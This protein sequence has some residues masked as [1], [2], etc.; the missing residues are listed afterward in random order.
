MV[1]TCSPSPYSAP[2]LALAQHY[3]VFGTDRTA[4]CCSTRR[5][6]AYAPRFVIGTLSRSR[7]AALGGLASFGVSAWLVDEV[8]NNLYTLLSSIP[9]WL[10]IAACVLMMQVLHRHASRPVRDRAERSDV[11][12]LSAVA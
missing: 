11:R 5:S 6:K 3:H 7:R 10:L 4:R 9:T 8:V 1:V 2:L 12:P